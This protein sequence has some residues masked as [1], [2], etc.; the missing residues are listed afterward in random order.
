[1]PLIRIINIQKHY[2]KKRKRL[3]GMALRP[4]STNGGISVFDKDCANEES[5]TICKHIERYYP[6]VAGVP[7]V[8]WEIPTNAIPPLP[9]I[10]KATIN[11][12]GDKCHYEFFNWDSEQSENVIRGV[13]LT[14]LEICTDKGIRKFQ[15]TDLPK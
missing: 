2:S 9:C 13:P 1:M 11:S 7:M 12:N 8:F 15:I 10:A 5:T 14:D 4:S 6:A 3:A